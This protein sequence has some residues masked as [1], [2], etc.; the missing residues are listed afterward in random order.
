VDG[1]NGENRL[2]ATGATQSQAWCH[3][4]FMARELGMLAGMRG[5]ADGGA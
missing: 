1:S 4:C 2:L 3:A 5:D